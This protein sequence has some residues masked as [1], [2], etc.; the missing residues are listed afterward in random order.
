MIDEKRKIALKPYKLVELVTIYGY[1]K[2]I[3]RQKLKEHKKDIGKRKGHYYSY[4]QILI[5]FKLIHLP[6]NIEIIA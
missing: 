5:I 1:S 4:E 3:M 6:S 2:Y